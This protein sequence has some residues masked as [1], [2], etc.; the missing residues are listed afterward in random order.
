[1]SW[2]YPFHNVFGPIVSALYAG[3]AIILKPSEFVAWSTFNYYAKIISAVLASCDAPIDLVQF[4]YGGAQLGEALVSAAGINK[5]TF[6]GSP[7]VGKLV[8][9]AAANRLTPV[10]LELGGKDAAIIC[11]DA[12]IESVVPIVMRGTFQNVGQNCVGLERVV[13][14]EGVYDKF[15]QLVLPLVEPLRIGDSISEFVDCGSMSTPVQLK[16]V[17]QMVQEAVKEGA[18]LLSGGFIMHEDECKGLFYAPTVL[19]NVTKDMR[20]AN[21]EVFGPVMTV[22]KFKTDQEAMDIVNSSPFGLGGSVFSSDID[23]AEKIVAGLDVGMCNINDFGINYL[24]QSL[25]FGGVKESG[26]GRFAGVEGLRSECVEKSITRDKVSFV[27]TSIPP[28]LQYPLKKGSTDFCCGLAHLAY[29]N[30]LQE[31]ANGIFGLLKGL[32]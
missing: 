31:R 28:P 18:E 30:D 21:T 5:V 27:K 14:Q 22:I 1:V 12:D 13:I 3:N 8:M 9:K 6:I 16:H 10:T 25:P 11:D 15:M 26:F 7:K 32:F 23:R 17:H 29:G 4:V 19:T 20:I 24:C 2:N